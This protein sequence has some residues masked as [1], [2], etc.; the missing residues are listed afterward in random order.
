MEPLDLPTYLAG[1]GITTYR[2][3]GDEITAHCWFCPDQNPKGRG[4]LYINTVEGLYFCFRCEARGNVRTL[5]RHFGDEAPQA[6]PGKDAGAAQRALAD[7]LTFCQEQLGNRDDIMTYLLTA[8]DT[9]WGPGRGL[10]AETV[11]ERGYGWADGSWSIKGYLLDRGHR[12][13]DINNAGLLDH[14]GQ[15]FFRDDLIIPYVVRGTVVALRAKK[16]GGKYRTSPGKDNRLY[17]IDDLADAAEVVIT[18]GEFDRDTLK[19]KLALSPDA[20]ARAMGVVGIP[21]AHVF[22]QEWVRLFSRAKRVYVALDPDDTGRKAAIRLKEM[23]GQKA[24]IVE[25]PEGLP[26]RDWT[27]LMARQGWTW[28]EARQ[29]FVAASGSRLHSYADAAA[30]W[31]KMQDT[32]GRIKL[33]IRSLDL[34]TGGMVPGQLVIPLAKTGTGK[35]IFLCNV[36]Y[37]LRHEPQLFVSLEMT[38]EEVY[39]RLRRIYRFFHPMADIH[40]ASEAF[41]KLRI[42]DEN[43]LGE[44]EL[45]VLCEEFSDDLGVRPRVMHVDYLGYYARGFKGDSYERTSAA[46]MA[47]K[48]VAKAEKLVVISPGQVNRGAEDGRPLDLDDARDSGV[49]EETA[50]FLPSIYRPELAIKDENARSV[51]DGLV[52]MGLLKSRHGGTGRTID[53]KFGPASLVMADPYDLTDRQ[54][55]LLMEE[56]SRT[57]HGETY[58]DI[59]PAH[60]Q[61]HLQVVA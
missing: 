34:I 30:S 60:A 47:L 57:F 21:G 24:R 40:E 23:I 1:K 10:S 18:E 16:L 31:R 20:K 22:P 55:R 43:R 9:Q 45:S 46:A 29:L 35:T 36:A 39:D 13:E 61:P 50:D 2:G 19:A 52:R 5:M 17:G 59:Y 6:L 38:A 41:S 51:P 44:G 42:V 7:A 28:R 48:G 58:D 56:N 25:M 33:G 14:A 3:G 54:R 49:I 27:E 12:M 8:G 15:D 11:V 4:K 37:N 26:K 32:V 53:L